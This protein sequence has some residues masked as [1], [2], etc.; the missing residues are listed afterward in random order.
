VLAL[1]ILVP[2]A[3]LAASASPQKC[4]AGDVACVIAFGD[5]DIA[6]RQTAL[7]TL[8]GKITAQLNK[9]NITSDQAN[10]LQADVTT[11]QTGLATLKVTLDAE[12]T[13]KAARHDV[14]NIFLVFRIFAVVLPRDY[15][16]LHLDVEINIK[17]RLKNLEPVLQQAIN[18]APSGNQAQL[19]ALFSDYETQVAAAETQIDT[20]Q[21]IIPTLTP[22]SFNTNPAAYKVTLS[23]LTAAEKAANQDLHQAAKDLD[24]ITKLLK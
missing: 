14:Q 16:Q 13:M 1:G 22:A 10:V 9:N 6:V 23:N 24:K 17:T 12:T 11:N 21:T 2:T 5:Q 19:N 3:A 20:A 4:A 8:S 7:T 18:S 15:H